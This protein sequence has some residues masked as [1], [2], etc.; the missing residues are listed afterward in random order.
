MSLFIV[1]ALTAALT[2]GGDAP[3]AKGDGCCKAGGCPVAAKVTELLT[4][5]KDATEAAKAV[6]AADR[7]KMAARMAALASDCP[8]GKRLSPTL[9]ASRDLLGYFAQCAE[10]CSK[11]CPIAKATDEQKK[12]PAFQAAQEL[13]AANTKMI[14]ELHQLATYATS[15]SSDAKAGCDKAKAAGG[16]MQSMVGEGEGCSAGAKAAD[17]AKQCPKE[18]ATRLATLKTSWSTVG[19][20]LA[21]MPVAKKE[22]LHKAFME[23]STSCKSMAL[24]PSTVSA[25]ADGFDALDAMHAKFGEWAQANPTVMAGVSEEAKKTCEANYALLRDM[26]AIMRQ[27]ATVMGGGDCSKEPSKGATAGTK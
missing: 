24:M 1:T 25:L 15:C 16:S 8:I 3:A 20:E 10:T 22:E 18:L 19:A 4:S 21:A 12:M 6:P 23:M 17:C 13:M 14:K 26:R 2:L 27:S 9:V 5:W 11:D 7:E